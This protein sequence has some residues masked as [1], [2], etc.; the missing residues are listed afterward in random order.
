[1]LIHVTTREIL[2]VE[3]VTATQGTL[4]IN[5]NVTE[6]ASTME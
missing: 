6:Q 5:A 1:M 3:F 2:Y 4:E